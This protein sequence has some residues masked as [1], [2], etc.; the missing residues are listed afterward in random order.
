MVHGFSSYLLSLTFCEYNL[1]RHAFHAHH[2]CR[3]EGLSGFIGFA[4]PDASRE[5]EAEKIP[6]SSEHIWASSASNC[7]LAQSIGWSCHVLFGKKIGMFSAHPAPEDL[8]CSLGGSRQARG[9]GFFFQSEGA[10]ST[11]SWTMRWTMRWDASGRQWS[12][13]TC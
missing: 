13:D 12:A 5:L 1:A 4:A 8:S 3:D 7:V 6:N 11:R 10:P 2:A 9:Q